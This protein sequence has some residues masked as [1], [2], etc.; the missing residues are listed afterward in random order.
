MEVRER[1]IA[2]HRA[3]YS[4]WACGDEQLIGRARPLEPCPLRTDFQ[5]DRDRIIHCKAF[6]RMK[7]KTQCFLAP[8]GDHF[9]TRLTHTL[10]V[11]Q[12]ARTIA[13]ALQLNEDL[14]EAIA[15]GHDLGHTPFGHM[16][17]RILAKLNKN[18]FA[19]E[20]QS[21]R[22]VE[23]LEN[24]GRGLNLTE[25]VRDGIAQHTSHGSPKTLEG[26]V[27]SL[28]DRIAYINHDIDD[29]IRAGVLK[30]E[31]LPNDLLQ[32]LGRSHGERINTMITDVWRASEGKD[33]VRMSEN[34]Y[35]ATMAL[36]A[37]MFQHVYT[38]GEVEREERKAAFLLESLFG[39]YLKNPDQMPEEFRRTCERETVE[40]AVCD[41]IAGM[42]DNY[43]VDRFAALFIPKHQMLLR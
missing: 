39:H 23:M 15:L 13:R 20:R 32:V 3:V 33:A 34:V 43:A 29:A 17:E 21:L 2:Q 8:E 16:G 5:R 19:H 42:T 38:R 25:A 41:Y 40:Q 12:I 27:V 22:V 14:T 6:R 7:H 31:E 11:A 24:D 36:R 37:F 10:E 9:R 28:S 26:A 1:T 4:P 35:E 18:G 30:A